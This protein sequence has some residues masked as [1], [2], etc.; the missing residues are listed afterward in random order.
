MSVRLCFATHNAGKLRELRA[1]VAGAGVDVVTLGELGVPD[2][3]E[4]TGA[5]FEDNARLKARAAHARTGLWALADDSGL[6]VDALGGAPGVYSA[7]FG[8]EPKSD[9]NNRR[10]LLSALAAVGP[11]AVGPGA[12]VSAGPRSGRFR[13]VLC[14]VGPSREEVRSGALEGTLLTEERGS[15]GFGYDPLFVPR[16]EDLLGVREALAKLGLL[17]EELVGKTL[18]E[19]PL[20]VKNL[21]SH[22][23]RAL[24]EMRP[25]LLGIAPILSAQR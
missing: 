3:V 25:E 24:Q 14:L 8:G 6:E 19:L 11:G 16:A 2:D 5:T 1:V 9:A 15:G 10:A 17:A 4:E 23:G 21:I 22:R 12:V 13:C 7:R 18:A 20:E